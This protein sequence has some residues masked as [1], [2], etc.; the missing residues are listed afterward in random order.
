MGD[1]FRVGVVGAC[2]SFTFYFAESAIEAEGVEFC[3]IADQGRNPEYIH[4]SLGLPWLSKYPKKVEGICELYNCQRYTT[5]EEL[6]AAERLDGLCVT[7]E[8][9]LHLPQTLAAVAAGCHVF[10]PK[11][12]AASHNEAVAMF[13]A[14]KEAG[15][16]VIGAVPVHYNPPFAKAAEIIKSGRIG[17]PLMGSFFTNHH[18]SLA[19]WKGDPKLA[20]GPQ[21]EFGFYAFDEMAMLMQAAPRRMTAYAGNLDHP[22]VD[23][24]DNGV[25]IVEFETGAMASAAL[26]YGI[27]YRMAG[28][29]PQIVGDKA[30]L[31]IQASYTD[32]VQR[33]LIYDQDGVEEIEVPREA[34]YKGL[35]M[36]NWVRLCQEG[37]DPTPSQVEALK[38]LDLMESFERSY[39]AG[40][41]TIAFPL[42]GAE[43]WPA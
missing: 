33:I 1:A 10:V 17:R 18:L 35:E 12:F 5:A 20:S 8:D 39:L 25:C 27:H 42:E 21:Y 14:G 6:I 26:R 24:I 41:E 30:G 37:G 23:Y 2:S 4:E 38:S 22:G 9:A 31:R 11:P 3:G 36:I 19:G 43:A 28:T 16:V 40:G 29:G 32:P 15:K 13:K 7:C 34:H